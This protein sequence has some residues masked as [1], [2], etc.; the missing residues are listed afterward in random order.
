MKGDLS[1]QQQQ[2]GT[3]GVM[4][5]GAVAALAFALLSVLWLVVPSLEQRTDRSAGERSV[6]TQGSS[7]AGR[8]TPPPPATGPNTTSPDAVG[9][10]QTITRSSSS[11]VVF[12]AQQI[13]AI[14]NFAQG[15]RHVEPADISISVGAAVPR[16]VELRDLPDELSRALPSHA[17]DQ[18]LIAGDQFVLVEK[19]S[20]RI[21]AI[22]PI[23]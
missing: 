4:F 9:R 15:G 3:S 11:T 12:D 10:N 7:V 14:R 1:R 22:A 5:W 23:G 18:Y 19:S 13:E 6:Q 20:R 16:T 17:G 2:R 8:D 21:I